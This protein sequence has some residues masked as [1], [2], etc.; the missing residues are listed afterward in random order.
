MVDPVHK[1]RFRCGGEPYKDRN[2]SLRAFERHGVELFVVG[3]A[4]NE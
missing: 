4:V 2:T 3:M 1:R